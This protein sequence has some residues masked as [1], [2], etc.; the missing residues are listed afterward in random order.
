MEEFA[1]GKIVAFQ[2]LQRGIGKINLKGKTLLIPE[3]NRI[4]SHLLASVMRSFGINARVL[5]TFLGLDLGKEYTSGKE[6]F[7]CQITLGDILY[8][9]KEESKRSPKGFDPEEYLYFMPEA[10][11]PCR[12]GMYNKYQRIVLDSLEELKDLKIVALTTKDGYALDGLIEKERVSDLR[13]VA[14]LSVVV[15]DVLDR[16]L[17]RIRPYEREKGSADL[18][19]DSATKEMEMA[20]QRWG[21]SKAF[22]RIIERL[23]D[24]LEGARG[25]VDPTIPQRP[26]IGI[27]GEIYVRS[28]IRSNQDTIRMIETYGGEVVNAS[29][30]EW[31]NYT[32]YERLREAKRDL[33]LSLRRWRLGRAREALRRLLNYGGDLLY[34]QMR[35]KQVF[36]EVMKVIPLPADHK[37]SYLEG[38]LK[39]RGLYNFDVGTEACLSI[40]GALSYIEEGYNGV[41]NLYP[42]TCM[43]STITAAILRPLMAK[44]N[45]PYLDLAYDSSVQP[46]REVAIR[47]F[48]YQATIHFKKQRKGN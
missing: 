36:K 23:L 3:M 33:Y 38:I 31:M 28:H 42:F 21:A 30:A 2:S 9:V 35:Q 26:K 14:Y 34:Q 27:V 7:P 8:F 29:I 32:S 20:F 37:I 39:D 47:T 6:C 48:M 41:V 5:P 17:W 4:G 16:L 19:V 15:G 40:P 25:I 1:G 46:N 44:M 10:E 22:D 24:L 43:P 12:F 13:K 18:Y 45:I 11:G